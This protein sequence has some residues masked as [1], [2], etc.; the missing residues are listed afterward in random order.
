MKHITMAG[1]M[2]DGKVGADC[3]C[4][5]KVYVYTAN[6]LF[7]AAHAANVHSLIH[8]EAHDG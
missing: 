2:A 1:T 6:P 8:T 4:G 3:S 5:W 7:D